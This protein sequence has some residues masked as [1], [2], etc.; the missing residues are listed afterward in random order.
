MILVAGLAADPIIELM[1]SRLRSERIDHRFLDIAEIQRTIGIKLDVGDSPGLRGHIELG[2]DVLPIADVG[3]AFVR[4]V[5]Y[6]SARAEAASLP[7]SADDVLLVRAERQAAAVRLFDHLP[8]LVINRPR[9]SITN[10]SKPY[11]QAVI[12]R[13]GLRTPTTLI[14]TNPMRARE[15]IA[16][17]RRVIVKSV[18]GV[19]SKVRLVAGED[20][21]LGRVKN[22]PTQ[23]QEEIRGSD[24][25]VHVVSDRVHAVQIDSDATDYRYALET[26]SSL[27]ASQIT[28]PASVSRAVVELTR[29][30]GLAFSGIDLKRTP[31]GDWYCFEVN[32]APGFLMY[33][34]LSGEPISLAVAQALAKADGHRSG[35]RERSRYA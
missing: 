8:A 17:H 20:P 22:C 7:L 26:G 29:R 31:G 9:A 4:L 10:H 21:R 33:E 3:S 5:E 32:P 30:L 16:A 18:S 23:F 25:R 11:Q 12:R 13:T 15:F 19:R 1:R 28:L 2:A 35:S 24:V 14:T 6:Q 27:T 34:R